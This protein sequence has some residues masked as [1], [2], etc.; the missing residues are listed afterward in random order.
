MIGRRARRRQAGLVLVVAAGCGGGAG[1]GRYP[2][3]EVWHRDG[4][5]AEDS[6][7]REGGRAADGGSTSRPPPPPFEPADATLTR[8]LLPGPAS[9]VGYGSATCTNAVPARADVWCAFSQKVEGTDTTELWV[10]NFTA[11]RASGAPRCDGTNAGCL[12]LSSALWTAS[13]SE[14]PSHPFS[15]RFDGDTLIFHAG[16]AVAATEE[17]YEGPVW[18]WRPGWS[19][20]RRLTSDHGFS[21][22]GDRGAPTVSCVDAALFEATG[23]FFPKF[24]LRA[25][26]LRAGRLGDVPP[27]DV[28]P[29]VEHLEAAGPGN[30]VW[31]AAFTPKGERF[32]YSSATAGSPAAVVKSVTVAVAVEGGAGIGTPVVLAEDAVDWR[33]SYDGAR[34]YHRQGV[35]LGAFQATGRL[36]AVRLP[37]NPAGE[38]EVLADNVVRYRLLGAHE[39][40]LTDADRGL[41]M[42]QDDGAGDSLWSLLADPSRPAELLP[43]PTAA[44]GV[45]VATDLRHSLFYDDVENGQPHIHIVRNDRSGRCSPKRDPRSETYGG[46][47]SHTSRLVFWIEYRGDSEEGWYAVPETCG[48]ARK[49]GDYVTGF[50]PVGDDFVVFRGTDFEDS[51]YHLEYARLTPDAAIP[52]AL[53]RMIARDVDESV[54]VLATGDNIDVLYALSRED[55]PT[56]GIFVHGPLPR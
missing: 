44:F 38:V 56:R 7:D 36:A 31:Q 29:L 30:L 19:E 12:R 37:P 10:F 25:L 16:V 1:A 49:F 43:F 2:D 42:E 46:H 51:A 13:F 20:A 41:L 52:R 11:A 40:I 26:D 8:L 35:T 24:R 28:L 48:E 45:E 15:H 32:V 5:S 17:P 27:D 14:G 34:L 47:F 50:I 23:S 53:P 18:A 3:A 6:G 21:C 33:I 4:A 22:I 54:V 39:E 55:A 9:L